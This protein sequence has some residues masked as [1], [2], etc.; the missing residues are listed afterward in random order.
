MLSFMLAKDTTYCDLKK[1][2]DETEKVNKQLTSTSA[3]SSTINTVMLSRNTKKW[4]LFGVAFL[5]LFYFAVHSGKI[6]A[7]TV[8]CLNG[9]QDARPENRAVGS[10]KTAHV[11]SDGTVYEYDR[12][13]PIIFIGGVP[14]SGTTLMRAMLD[15]HDEVR[16]G[17]ETRV[18]P[19][20]LQVS[21][22]ERWSGINP[23][24]G[25]CL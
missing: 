23:K 8:D 12:N 5:G 10:R 24:F 2:D 25:F 19:R 6:S 9:G 18:V 1:Y 4:L 14:R 22:D 21:S 7:N 11:S 15:A 16:C 20:I 3:S 17:E 13:S